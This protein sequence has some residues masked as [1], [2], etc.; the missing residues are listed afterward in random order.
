MIIIHSSLLSKEFN[1]PKD[2]D[3]NIHMVLPLL[4]PGGHLVLIE[5]GNSVGFETI[6]R[7]RQI[8]IRPE[9]YPQELGKI[10]RP[11]IK[12]SKGKPQKMKKKIS[13]LLKKMLN[14]KRVIS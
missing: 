4:A 9:S 1:F 10:P 13:L 11:Y 12:G 3:D 14:L 2:V 7:A 5:R 8:M 6:A